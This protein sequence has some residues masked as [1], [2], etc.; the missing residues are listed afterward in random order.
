MQVMVRIWGSAA[1]AALA[2]VFLVKAVV[3]VQLR[4]HPFLQADAGLDTTVYLDLARRV[5][6]GNV[7]LGPVLYFVSPLYIYFTAAVLAIAQSL[8]IVR[9][10]QVAFGTAAVALVFLTAR[11]W[12]GRPAAWAA[13]TLAASRGS[14]PFTRYSCCRR[15]WTLS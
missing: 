14:S 5:L 2:T 7:A 12:F 1:V 8:T 13:A 6:D 11:L 10:V 3:L 9:V 4:N 15:R